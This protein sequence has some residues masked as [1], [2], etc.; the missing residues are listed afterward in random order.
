MYYSLEVTCTT[1]PMSTTTKNAPP[2][3]LLTHCQF[4]Q[5]HRH[6]VYCQLEGCGYGC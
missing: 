4:S 2:R 5:T 6:P 1:L 3:H